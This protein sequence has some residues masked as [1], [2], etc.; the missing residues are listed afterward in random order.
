MKIQDHQIS[1]KCFA[2]GNSMSP[3]S[4]QKPYRSPKSKVSFALAKQIALSF[5]AIL[6]KYRCPFVASLFQKRPSCFPKRCLLVDSQRVNENARVI[7]RSLP[8]SLFGPCP[9]SSDTKPNKFLKPEVPS[10][11]LIT[12]SIYFR[13]EHLGGSRAKGANN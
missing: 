10:S 11:N 6:M 2:F 9:T 12:A 3:S 1:K 4:I 13:L 8:M 7:R 5:K